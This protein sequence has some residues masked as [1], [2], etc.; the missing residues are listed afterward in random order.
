M[1]HNATS[2]LTQS[3]ED[4]QT[5]VYTLQQTVK[6]NESCQEGYQIN[7]VLSRVFPTGTYPIVQDKGCWEHFEFAYYL[8]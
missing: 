6:P 1:F 8:L 7:F 5:T 3:C 2:H 4:T